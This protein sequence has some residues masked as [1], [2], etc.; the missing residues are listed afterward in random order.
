MAYQYQI[1][2]RF[3]WYNKMSQLVR[4]YFIEGIAFTFD[5]VPES[6]YYDQEIIDLADCMGCYEIEDLYRS[7]DYLISEQCHPILFELELKNPELMPTD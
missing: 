6:Y 2:C 1:S 7:S 3:C 5:E 4:M